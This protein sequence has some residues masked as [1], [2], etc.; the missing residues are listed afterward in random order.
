MPRGRRHVGRTSLNLVFA[1]CVFFLDLFF[2]IEICWILYW[3]LS[4]RTTICL[5][6]TK[7]IRVSGCMGNNSLSH[8]CLKLKKIRVN[9]CM[10]EGN[11]SLSL[12][13]PHRWSQKCN[14][15]SNLAQTLKQPPWSQE[16]AQ[17]MQTQVTLH[18]FLLALQV[19]SSISFL[20]AEVDTSLDYGT[21]TSALSATE[22]PTS[23][24]VPILSSLN[25]ILLYGLLLAL[26]SGGGGCMNSSPRMHHVC[27]TVS[28][29]S[30]TWHA[31]KQTIFVRKRRK[32]RRV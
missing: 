31:T 15:C 2:V 25:V 18:N 10:T 19:R 32:K 28:S 13:T 5:S 24:Q 21:P 3:L 14:E 17:W 20:P 26:I 29:H 8:V 27:V 7:K 16:P 1:I 30:V 4:V 9:G 22:G 6:Q 12:S 23:H 11:N